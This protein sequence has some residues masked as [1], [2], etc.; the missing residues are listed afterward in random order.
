MSDHRNRGGDG[1]DDPGDVDP[2][3]L[4]DA[5][6][7]AFALVGN[8]T[9]LRILLELWVAEEP[10]TF[11]ELRDR[12]GMRD[13][14]QFNYHLN[15]LVGQLVRKK[16]D[17]GTGSTDDSVSGGGTGST[18][19]PGRNDAPGYELT[20]AGTQIV[21]S[22]YSG[23]FTKEVSVGPVEVDGTCYDCDS[24]FV[25]AYEDER[26]EVR[27]AECDGQLLSFPVPPVAVEHRD[28]DRLPLVFDDWMRAQLDLVTAG[29]CPLCTGPIDVELHPSVPE[30]RE[31]DVLAL[32]FECSRCGQSV[33]S[34]LGAA[35]LSNAEVVAF[36]L[37][38]GID[39]SSTPLWDLQWLFESHATVHG[40]DPP[41]VDLHVE[42]GDE[43]LVCDVG[44]DFR[45]RE[46][47][48]VPR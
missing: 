26:A 31:F 4:V 25:A 17:G 38:H 22:V 21:G 1:R 37:D 45:I 16:T 19:D 5:A 29:F 33:E 43:R 2:P 6:D 48:R 32:R 15:R 40:A 36:H 39:L 3:N 7:E 11:S 41:D 44:A 46:T 20:F 42:L 35:F 24:R 10:L 13:S 34:V 47:E 27:C 30:E 28:V 23:T 14:G 8:E 18:G 12:V 9:R